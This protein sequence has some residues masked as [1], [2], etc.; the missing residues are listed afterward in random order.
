METQKSTPYEPVSCDFIDQLEVYSLHKTPINVK[1][2]NDDGEVAWIKGTVQDIFTQ[3]HAEFVKLTEGSEI[4]LD[5][6]LEV[7]ALQQ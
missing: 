1:V 5:R 3:D 2:M 4:R 6:I 7:K